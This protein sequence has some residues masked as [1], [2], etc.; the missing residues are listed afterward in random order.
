[1]SSFFCFSLGVSK[2]KWKQLGQKVTEYRYFDE[3][4]AFL[5]AVI[6]FLGWKYDTL[7]VMG[8]LIGL[9]ALVL[10]WTGDFKFLIP[11]AVYLVFTIGEGFSSEEI[12]IPIILIA[13][14]FVIVLFL[15]VFKN[16]F[17]IGKTKFLGGLLGLAIMNVLPVFW[18]KTIAEEN[19]VF[20]VFFF[21]DLAYLIL[22]VL[23]SNGIRK[24]SLH[25]LSV[26][27]SYLALLL[28]AQCIDKVIELKGTTE[29]I[30][31]LWY[32]L[33]WGL[34]NEAGI[35]I[36]VSIPFIFYLMAT[37][38]SIFSLL[39]HHLK[40]IAALVGI[41]LTTSRG[42]YL[43]GFG[44]TLVFYFVLLFIAKKGRA[45]QNFLF[46][47]FTVG[48]VV[49]LIF[50]DETI[51][52]YH[53]IQDLVFTHGL[54]SNGRT[55]LWKWA[56]TLW[57][58]NWVNRIFGPGFCAAID[59]RPTP[60]GD[61]LTPIVFH[62]TFFQTLAMGGIFGVLCLGYH[63]I[64]KYYYLAKTDRVFFCVIG[65]G[66]L[67]VDVYGMIDNTYHMYYYMVPLMVILAVIDSVLKNR[68]QETTV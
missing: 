10:L 45:Y 11:N 12:P 49:V 26:T 33:G 21:A 8:I 43:F 44:E 20:Y 23:L 24:N 18:C 19:N 30:L 29:S 47:F 27:M 48:I 64:Q 40:V 32:Y 55:T 51:D 59:V 60:N 17:H 62:S 16:G 25:L 53:K 6:A 5:L 63:F 4:Y 41:V 38:D 13:V 31:D 42:S 1:M 66:F 54:D 57:N 2:M 9:A 52:L 28:T 58:E 14:V 7:I 3:L 67:F 39:G 61:Q 34:C 35:M 22:Y 15:G 68:K 37:A 56:C 36:C 46:V 65:I 50:K